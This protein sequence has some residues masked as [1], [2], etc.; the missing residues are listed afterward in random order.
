MDKK[1]RF[2]SHELHVYRQLDARLELDEKNKDHYERLE[3]GY[4]GELMFD[5]FTDRMGEE[6]YF[7]KDLLLEANNSVTQ[8][9]ST[10]LVERAVN[11]FE[12]K[13]YEGEYVYDS[14]KFYL[15]NGDEIKNPFEQLGRI[16][17]AFRRYIRNLGYNFPIESYLIFVNPEFTLYQAPKNSSIILPTQM[18]RFITKLDGIPSKLNLKHE[19][20]ADKLAAAHLCKNPYSR[21]PVYD[22]GS[23]KKGMLC[24]NGHF[25]TVSV[26]GNKLTCEICDCIEDLDAAVIR[27]VK[28]LRLLLPEIKI[29]RPL[30]MEWCQIVDSKKIF[31]RILKQLFEK[32][33]YGRGHFYK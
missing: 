33:G 22:F 28:E 21:F 4:L 6:R 24:K 18:N 26:K 13:N 32:D 27:A 31:Y 11:L 1:A 3:K 10:M 29:T 8:V 30:A 17:S 25:G 5:Q 23:L 2:V 16:E 19:V 20:L 7:L 9:D 12:V 15:L 14:G